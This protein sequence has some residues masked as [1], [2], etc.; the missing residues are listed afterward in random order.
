MLELIGFLLFSLVFLYSG[1]NHV[2]KHEVLSGY[3]STVLKDFGWLGGWPTGVYLL[4]TGVL[5]A[6]QVEAGLWLGAAFLLVTAALFHRDFQNDPNT[7]KN[8]ALAGAA[9]ALASCL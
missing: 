3:A 9:L 5:V 1:Y 6:F 8:I 4:V 7:F 2:V